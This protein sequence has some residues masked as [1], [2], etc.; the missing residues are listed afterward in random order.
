MK[1]SVSKLFTLVAFS[2]A[3]LVDGSARGQLPLA[4]P[5]SDVDSAGSTAT[6]PAARPASP[7]TTPAGQPQ[8]E[9]LFTPRG[10][11]PASAASVSP[12]ERMNQLQQIYAERWRLLDQLNQLNNRNA[13]LATAMTAAEA[14]LQRIVATAAVRADAG[15]LL[16][17]EITALERD[18]G[19]R[20]GSQ[21]LEL[22]R[23]EYRMLAQQYAE[24]QAAALEMQTNLEGLNQQ[25]AANVM[26]EQRV[27]A[28]ADQLREQWLSAMGLV[29][30]LATEDWQATLKVVDEWIV[31]EPEN[32]DPYFVRALAFLRMGDV[33]RAQQDLKRSV[34]LTENADATLL[35]WQGLLHSLTGNAKAGL[36][37]Y[38]SALRQEKSNPHAYLFRGISHW[39]EGKP[40]LAER[41][42]KS[43]LQA[44]GNDPLILHTVGLFYATN[45][46]QTLRNGRRAAE[47]AQRAIEQTGGT[48]WRSYAVLAMAEAEQGSF[49]A[50]AEAAE[51]AAALTRGDNQRWCQQLAEQ[52][53]RQQ[54]LEYPTFD[55]VQFLP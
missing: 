54:P 55:L 52:F 25:A 41:D 30:M 4:P 43:A 2:L 16:E 7:P 6:P 48:D 36:T 23:A 27:R 39:N 49:A 45:S 13:E 38:G 44:G 5:P 32:P 3:L 17:R 35:A 26:E 14:R 12:L 50:A 15:R 33:A 18:S 28:Q 20:R 53:S 42:F 1:Y 11:S 37:N 51:K 22:R 46:A 40:P 24:L 29:G 19:G 8:G 47:L 31:L 21:A 9:P 10:P 34:E